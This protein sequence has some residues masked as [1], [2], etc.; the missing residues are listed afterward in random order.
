MTKLRW[1]FPSVSTLFV[2]AMS[3]AVIGQAAGAGQHSAAV[4]ISQE[5]DPRTQSE[6]PVVRLVDR[7]RNIRVNLWSQ[8]QTVEQT[9]TYGP[10]RLLVVGRS[11]VAQT[12]AVVSLQ[13]GTVKDEL[14]GYDVSLSPSRQFIAYERFSQPHGPPSDDV[15]MIYDLERTADANR[16]SPQTGL[17]RM[18]YVGTPIFPP[19]HALSR[20]YLDDQEA[21]ADRRITKLWWLDERTV[22]FISYHPGQSTLVTVRE[23]SGFARP[24]YRL[25]P[26]DHRAIV[27]AGELG[28]GDD[29]ALQF[30]GSEIADD[31]EPGKIT[32]KLREEPGLKVRSIAIQK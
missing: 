18:K 16:L 1:V 25:Y 19:R 15:V 14:L 21:N 31:D 32:V 28:I 5:R 23:S 22:A 11:S 20:A 12:V 9:H 24:S 27:N 26:L 7:G 4:E 13:D 17:D 8:V 29:P 3:V 2:L 30:S 6:R 10:D